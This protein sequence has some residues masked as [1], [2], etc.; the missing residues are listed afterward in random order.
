MPVRVARSPNG[1]GQFLK[2]PYLQHLQGPK[3]IT[4]PSVLIVTTSRSGSALGAMCSFTTP[5]QFA[6]DVV[7]SLGKFVVHLL[8]ITQR[9]LA[10]FFL[11]RKNC[12]TTYG[13][14]HRNKIVEWPRGPTNRQLKSLDFYVNYRLGKIKVCTWLREISSCSCLTVLP[15]PAWV[16]LSKTCKPLF[17][18]L[19][20]MYNLL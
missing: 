13:E 3:V 8:S 2:K 17:A 9:S 18:P 7:F 14:N 12:E 6:N 19:Y 20:I 10:P 1:L 5:I 4:Q 11:Y 15:G 16:L